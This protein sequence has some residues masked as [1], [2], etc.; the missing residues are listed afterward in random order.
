MFLKNLPTG[1]EDDG[2]VDKGFSGV[3]LFMGG[4]GGLLLGVDEEGSE[5]RTIACA[6]PNT[7]FASHL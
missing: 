4:T 7:F 2:R 6:D 5:T 3:D 1:L